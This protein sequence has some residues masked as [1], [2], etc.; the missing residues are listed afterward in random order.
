MYQEKNRRVRHSLLDEFIY[1]ARPPESIREQ[2]VEAHVVRIE[3]EYRILRQA[4][5]PP[6]AVGALVACKILGYD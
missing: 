3:R 4:G 1:G 5:K 2:L 6:E